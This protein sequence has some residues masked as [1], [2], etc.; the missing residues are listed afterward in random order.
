MKLILTAI[1]ALSLAIIPASQASIVI[2]IAGGNY[3]DS[4][5]VPVAGGTLFQLINL[6]P[7]GVFNQIDV[8]ATDPDTVGLNR[9]VSGDDSV[10]SNVLIGDDFATTAA[11]DLARGNDTTPGYID[12]VL[13]L[14]AP[15][16][17]VGTKYGIRWF[18]GLQATNFATIT[19][20]GNQKYGQFNR[21]TTPNGLDPWIINAGDGATLT[22]EPLLTT[23][24]GGTDGEGVGSLARA[25]QTVV[26]E[27]GSL[28][29]AFMGAA[30]LA[31]L[32][33]RRRA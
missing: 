18:P 27:P 25:E 29:L 16:P 2:S 26:P 20:A 14:G 3:L 13:E 19:L 7:D 15:L 31:V 22:P 30:G 8:G 24:Q 9:W 11:F 21:L 28:A 10:I 6:G 33:R 17:A 5:G 32:R 23:A 4:A 12:R 1:G